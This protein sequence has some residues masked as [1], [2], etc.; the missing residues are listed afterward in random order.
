MITSE[1]TY[2]FRALFLWRY[3]SSFL[4]GTLALGKDKRYCTNYALQ[5]GVSVPLVQNGAKT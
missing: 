3:H 4:Q 5:S 2:I 1:G